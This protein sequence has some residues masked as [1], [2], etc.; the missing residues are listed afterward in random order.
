LPVIQ[1]LP[2]FPATVGTDSNVMI[3]AFTRLVLGYV[4]ALPFIA[5]VLSYSMVGE[6]GHALLLRIASSNGGP[7]QLFYDAGIGFAH[8][9]VF[10]VGIGLAAFTA[11]GA[12]PPAA[13]ASAAA[14]F[15]SGFVYRF[16]HPA[17]F[18][19]TYAP[20]ALFG[21]FLLARSATIHAQMAAAL[22]IARA[23]PCFWS[24]RH[25]KRVR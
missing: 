10:A 2:F 16:S 3:V 5:I 6:Q 25:P 8:R 1:R 4:L 21:W 22:V 12:W 23:H 18:S 9:F 19:L 14:P 13:I 15:V 17:V 11:T 24:R 7:L 20:L